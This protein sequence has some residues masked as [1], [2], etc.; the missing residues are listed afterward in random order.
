MATMV[1]ISSAKKVLT[2]HH[3]PKGKDVI[4]FVQANPVTHKEM[5]DDMAGMDMGDM[6]GMDGADKGSGAMGKGKAIEKKITVTV[7]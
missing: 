6:S 7:Q 3:L 4:S 1:S 2:L 5:G